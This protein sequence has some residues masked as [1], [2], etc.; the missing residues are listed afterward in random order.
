MSID[1]PD[2]GVTAPA[3]Q[4]ERVFRLTITKVT[5]YL[6]L[7]TRKT[8]SFVGTVDELQ[9]QYRKVRFH[10]LMLG[11]WGIP[12]GFIWTP[13]SLAANA[14]ALKQLEQL[15]TEGQA[16]PAATA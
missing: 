10:N 13:R 9:R 1:T 2:A 8:H 11:W 6:F 7:T 14:K 12:A 4:R 16:G 15:S 3:E 5:S